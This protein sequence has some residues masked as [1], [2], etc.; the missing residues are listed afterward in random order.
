MYFQKDIMINTFEFFLII[1][2]YSQLKITFR[3]PS[4]KLVV[5]DQ[6]F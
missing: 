2:M 1:R 3:I 4:I 5:C 6:T